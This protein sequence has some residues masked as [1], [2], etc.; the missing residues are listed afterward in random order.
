MP[1]TPTMSA[2]IMGDPLRYGQ[3]GGPNQGEQ[4]LYTGPMPRPNY[5]QQ[6][7][8]GAG[9]PLPYGSYPGFGGGVPGLGPQMP[10]APHM[11]NPGPAAPAQGVT[12][13]FSPLPFQNPMAMAMPSMGQSSTPKPGA[14]GFPPMMHAKLK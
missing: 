1:N 10:M 4:M 3:A 14:F 12:Q 13:A 11:S 6:Y 8:A 2:Q 7:G 5:G 9:F